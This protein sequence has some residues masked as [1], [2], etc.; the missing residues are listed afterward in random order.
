MNRTS[1]RAAAACALLATTAL[2]APAFAQT[3]PPKFDAIDANGVDLVSGL[4]AGVSITE[5]SI[6][7][8]PGAVS[9]TRSWNGSG[10]WVGN[11]TGL[12]Y[13]RTVSG[14]T[15]AYVELGRNSDTFTISG[16]T[17]TSTK[18]DG[19]TL[20]SNGDGQLTYTAPD[21]TTIVYKRSLR[22]EEFESY[23]VGA[24]QCGPADAGT[25]AIPVSVDTPG[26]MTFTVNWDVH[27]KCAGYD[28]NLVCTQ[29][30]AFV[31]FDGVTSD[32]SYKFTVNY[33][34]DTPGNFA[35]PQSDWYKKS[36]V[37]FTNLVSTPASL[38]TVTYPTPSSGH[39]NFTDPAGGSWSISATNGAITGITP[40]GASSAR[41][42]YAYTNGTV[43][44]ATIDGVTTGY[45]RAVSGTTAT[46][47]ITNALSQQ[48][49]VVV[50]LAR[51]G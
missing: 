27:F 14:Q 22:D 45:S 8:G 20:V 46:T 23:A 34:T 2:S 7:S 30:D 48:S 51:A 40:P 44:S 35:A 12:M 17:Y 31:R 13:H 6:G 42:T 39:P 41:T 11:W 16:S 9:L 32:A 5:G 24:P 43:S 36:S 1:F 19:A 3:P 18:A 10:Y 25:C 4:P 15:L 49:V 37:T 50:D 28:E 47:T 29:R 38:P 26:G 21:G 33:V